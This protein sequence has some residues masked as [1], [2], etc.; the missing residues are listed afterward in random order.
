MHAYSESKPIIELDLGV[1]SFYSLFNSPYPGHYAATALDIYFKDDEALFPFNE[2]RVLRIKWF[3]APR[4]RPDAFDK[5]PLILVELAPGIVA[6]I[7]HVY[8]RVNIGEKLYYGDY[9]GD[10]IVSGY[11]YFWSER[12]MH[13]EVRS[14]HDPYRARGAFKLKIVRFRDVFSTNTIYGVVEL[15]EKYFILIK[16][17]KTCTLGPTPLYIDI[18]GDKYFIEGGYPHYKFIALLGS[19]I[20]NA[21]G[22]HIEQNIDIGYCYAN[23]LSADHK[24]MLRD[25][26]N[27]TVFN[28]VSVFFGREQ[29]KLVS[30]NIIRN[31]KEGDIIHIV[32]LKE[33]L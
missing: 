11:M 21:W 14:L 5:E 6:K 1:S 22:K 30:S 20:D 15:V 32:S 10:L 9:I 12:H 26:E 17:L 29:V 3:N 2:G 33:Y 24:I 19:Y 31:V 28:G 4:K 23:I 18:Y 7:L 16:P 25:K 8:P 13:V 27:N